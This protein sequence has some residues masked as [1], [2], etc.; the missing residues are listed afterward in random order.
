MKIDRDVELSVRKAFMAA[1]KGDGVGFNTAVQAIADQGDDFL[2]Q[3]VALAYAVD[4]AALFSIHSGQ[5]PDD[6]QLQLLAQEFTEQEEGWA[7]VA[8]AV[9]LKYLTSLADGTSPLTVISATDTTFASLAI[10]GW[11]LS[12]FVPEGGDWFDFLDSILGELVAFESL[13]PDR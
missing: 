1:V 9:T 7:D 3:A 2:A 4:A 12:A 5:R 11:L 13:Q 10:G 8:E 6:Q